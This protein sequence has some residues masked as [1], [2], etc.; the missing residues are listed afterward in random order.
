MF[1]K[2]LWLPAVIAAISTGNAFA[3]STGDIAFTAFNADEDGWS[4]AVLADIAADTPIFFQDNEATS[5][6]SF[7]T[8]ES[9]FSWNT[10]GSTIA[11]GTVVRFSAIDTASRMASL[12]SFSVVDGSNLGLSA[13]TETLYAFLGSSATMPTTFLAAVTTEGST[14][15]TPAGLTS[16]IDAIALTASTDFGEYTG[17]RSSQAVFGDY[18]G[19]VNN[20]ANWSI[21]IGGDNAAVIPNMTNFTIT[22]VPVPAALPLLFSGVA[23]LGAFVRR[24]DC[25]IAA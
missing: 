16:G 11:A 8:G 22:A 14:N 25:A 1:Q 15:L 7:N 3:V 4:I 9:S 23:L 5:L 17:D 6:T 12:G 21:D 10:G 19:L 24:R 20:A 13:S 18:L 2:K